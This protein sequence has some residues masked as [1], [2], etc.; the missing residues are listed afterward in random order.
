V[1]AA[2]NKFNNNKQLSLILNSNNNNTSTFRSDGGGQGGNNNQTG[3][4]NL[5]SAGLNYR[6]DF[7]KRN[8]FYGSYTYT[9]R[10]TLTES[11]TSR[12]S[13]YSIVTNTNQLPEIKRNHRAGNLNFG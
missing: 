6:T 2:I 8:S 3:I 13:H 10:N 12:N 9:D 7:G 4:T 5:N 1:A 11:Y